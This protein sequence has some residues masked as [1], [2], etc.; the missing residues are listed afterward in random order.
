M[1]GHIGGVSQGA[2]W[3]YVFKLWLAHG[4]TTVREPSGRSRAWALDLKKKSANNEIIAPRIVQYTGFGSGS[5]IP[6]V[7]EEQAREW[8]RKNAKAGSDG[9]KFLAQLQKSWKQLWMKIINLVWV[10]HVIMHNSV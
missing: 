7:T 6:I 8:V 5:K 10:L 2:D 9:I 1:H 3:D 4:V